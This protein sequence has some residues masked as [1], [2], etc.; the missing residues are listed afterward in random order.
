MMA[1]RRLMLEREVHART[2]EPQLAHEKS[3]RD[4]CGPVAMMLVTVRRGAEC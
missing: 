1:N 4:Q 3:Q 2:E